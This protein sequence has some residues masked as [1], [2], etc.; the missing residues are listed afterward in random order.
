MK[1]RVDAKKTKLSYSRFA[2]QYRHWKNHQPQSMRQVHIAGERTFIDYC[3]DTVAVVDTETGEIRRA[4]IFVGALGASDYMYFD[5]SWSQSIENWITSHV[6]ML[7]YFGGVTSLLTPDNL[8]AATTTADRYE[9]EINR[10]YAEFA[11]YYGTAIMPARPYKPK[12]KAKA[13]CTVLIV[14]RWVLMRLRNMTFYGLEQLNTELRKLMEFANNRKFKKMPGTRRE[15]F[16]ML[17]QPALKALP[18]IPYVF[19]QYKKGKVGVDYHVELLHHYYSVPYK[20]IGFNVDI[21]YNAQVV[22]IYANLECLSKHVR[23]INHGNT[24]I[25]EHMPMNHKKHVEW[26]EERCRIWAGTIGISTLYLVE[27]MLTSAHS[28]HA[29]RSCLGLMSLAKEYGSGRLEAASTY[30]LQV[31][32]IT[33]KQLIAILKS[34]LDQVVI[35]TEEE[36][37]AVLHENIRG[38]QYYS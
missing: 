21:W 25:S 5:A 1:I 15:M 9:A 17:D 35:S 36:S 34:N 6:R 19:K 37:P 10:T 38:S 14:Q 7:N 33:R 13:E 30:A 27:K 16:K 8:K 32:A 20:Y 26:T 4:Q 3:G 18:L 22:E 24:T 28:E 31:G 11:K 23:S 29:K 2:Y 12:D